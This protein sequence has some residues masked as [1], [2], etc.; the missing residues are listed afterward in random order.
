[1]MSDCCDYGIDNGVVVIG[2]SQCSRERVLDML[3]TIR[4]HLNSIKNIHPVDSQESSVEEESATWRTSPIKKPRNANSED[5]DAKIAEDKE[6]TLLATTTTEYSPY[7]SILRR[8]KS[9]SGKEEFALLEPSGSGSHRSNSSPKTVTSAVQQFFRTLR[10]CSLMI[11]EAFSSSGEIPA[12][13]R[14]TVE[15]SSKDVD[16]LGLSLVLEDLGGLF[17][18]RTL[19]N[20]KSNG[21]I[22]RFSNEQ[23]CL[24]ICLLTL[25]SEE[26]KNDTPDDD[27]LLHMHVTKEVCSFVDMCQ[28]EDEKL[29]MLVRNGE[30]DGV[31][32]FQTCLDDIFHSLTIQA[33]IDSEVPIVTVGLGAAQQ[34]IKR[35]GLVIACYDLSPA[36][37]FSNFE[38]ESLFLPPTPNLGHFSV[39]SSN[40]KRNNYVC[41]DNATLQ[42]LCDDSLGYYVASSFAAYWH[43][44]KMYAIPQSRNSLI[45]N[46]I[47]RRT[48]LLLGLIT[49]FYL[50]LKCLKVCLGALGTS[51]GAITPLFH[52]AYYIFSILVFSYTCLH[53]A[54]PTEDYSAMS[55]EKFSKV[56]QTS[57]HQ[58]RRLVVAKLNRFLTFIFYK[59]SRKYVLQLFTTALLFIYFMEF[60]HFS[61]LFLPEAN[62]SEPATVQRVNIFSRYA[63]CLS[64]LNAIVCGTLQYFTKVMMHKIVR[65]SHHGLCDLASVVLSFLTTGKISLFRNF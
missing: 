47:V 42:R 13:C 37:V 26:I 27:F 44:D 61:T 32:C 62:I 7:G 17:K 56:A 46:N 9:A 52:H 39:F 3:G 60:S 14:Q 18:R 6:R 30:V 23:P 38:I 55:H 50:I 2:A 22:L 24:G 33:C 25:A 29:S 15:T 63:I 45:I 16:I 19:V 8:T 59:H 48:F 34:I 53:F 49:F 54:Y 20:D 4:R 36:P 58:K 35:G 51:I 5:N 40:L 21:S 64:F 1:M 10:D 41:P 11:V 57:R 43:Q 12:L 28:I 31:L 65:K